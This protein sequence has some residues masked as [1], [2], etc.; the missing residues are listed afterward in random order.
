VVLTALAFAIRRVDIGSASLW[1][2]FLL[3]GAL[4]AAE[5]ADRTPLGHQI[6]GSNLAASSIVRVGKLAHKW[7]TTASF[8]AKPLDR[9]MM[10]DLAFNAPG[11]LF[12]SIGVETYGKSTNNAAFDASILRDA[13]AILASHYT[14]EVGQHEFKGATLS[15]EFRELCGLRTVGTPT[16]AKVLAMR[17]KCLRQR[18]AAK[19]FTSLGI[20]CNA[21]MFYNRSAA[22]RRSGLPTRCSTPT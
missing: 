18:L 2:G 15:G 19:G 21:G 13:E 7:M 1:P 22:I 5:M 8:T 9:P 20:H 4:F 11:Q 14:I 17:P 16:R 10:V 6:V 3:L 12:L